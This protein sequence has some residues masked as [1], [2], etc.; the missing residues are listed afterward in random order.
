MAADKDDAEDR[1]LADILKDDTEQA[2]AERAALAEAI[3]RAEADTYRRLRALS[4]FQQQSQQQI[5]L[6][7]DA[8]Q[9]SEG[10]LNALYRQRD[11]TGQG[12]PV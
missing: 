9:A 1:P 8:A 2:K 12:V 6:L 4:L 5:K 3:L 7:Q 10:N 11:T